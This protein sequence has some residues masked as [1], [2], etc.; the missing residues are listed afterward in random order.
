MCG[1]YTLATPD[2]DLADLL[3]LTAEPTLEPRYNIAPTQPVAVLRTPQVRPVRE[4]ELLQWG[5][6]PS[7][8]KDPT[9]GARMINAR[10][11]PGRR[12]QPR[13]RPFGR[14]FAS[15]DACCRPTGFMN[16]S[17]SAAASNPTTSG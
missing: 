8:A 13:S 6:V 9:I 3:D 11:T 14:R 10:S 17:E 1:R 12:P 4:L 2:P 7:W 15:A 5:L 16:G